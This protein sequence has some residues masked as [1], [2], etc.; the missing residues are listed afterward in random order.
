MY[1]EIT[2]EALKLFNRKLQNKIISYNDEGN[3]LRC[4][5]LKEDK[6]ENREKIIKELHSHH[7]QDIILEDSLPLD[8]KGI[9]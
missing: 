6:V 2:L 7:N 9:Y 3:N 1:K 5:E 8:D 4:F